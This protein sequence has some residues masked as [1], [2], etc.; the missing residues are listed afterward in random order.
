MFPE[1]VLEV[2]RRVC[3]PGGCAGSW[4]GGFVFSEGVLEVG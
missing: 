2:G 1:G 3:V 4:V